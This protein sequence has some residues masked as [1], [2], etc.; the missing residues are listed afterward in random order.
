MQSTDHGF[1]HVFAASF[2]RHVQDRLAL[3]SPKEKISSLRQNQVR[4]ACGGGAAPDEVRG[5]EILGCTSQSSREEVH[6]ELTCIV[7]P[8]FDESL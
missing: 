4:Q 5:G 6:S 7:K 2:S 8:S 1:E 3:V